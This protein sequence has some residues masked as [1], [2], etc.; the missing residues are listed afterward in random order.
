MG[1]NTVSRRVNLYING[2][3]AGREI[4]GVKAEM[5]KLVNEIARMKVG[6][7]EYVAH[8]QRIRELKAVVAEHN[9][10][11]QVTEKHWLSLSSMTDG[12]NK[13]F[14]MIGSFLAGLT[15]VVLGFRKCSDEAG[16][17]EENLDNLSALTGLEGK[18]LDWLGNQAK[19]MSVKTTESG[20]R[21][22]QSATDILD[23]F[24][25]M[26][27]QR[28]ELLKNKDAL[29]AV[30]EDAII[31]SEAAKMKLEPA[32]ASLASVM[33]Q[34]NT[35]SSESRR[36]IN[37]LAAGSQVGSGDIQY[38][39]DAI[40]KCGTSAYLMGMK[41]N[42][43][44]GVIEAV[45]PK[46]KEASVAGNSL[47]KVLLKMKEKQIGYQSGVFNF[48]DALDELQ[49]RLA[50][51]ESA[52]EL[53]G[54]EHAKMA[55]VLVLTKEDVIRYTEAVTDTNKA[56]EQAAKNTNNAVA[57]RAQA[58][59]KL[60]LKMIEVGEK[61]SPAITMSTNAFTYFLN[62]LVKA[63]R[64]YEENRR[65]IFAL[66][67][68][69]VALQGRT[70]LS[71]V[72][73][74]NGK[75]AHLQDAAAKMKNGL[76]T[77]YLNTYT[78][79][80]NRTQ[81]RLYPALLRAR[82]GFVML[83]RA[84]MANPIG[85]VVLAFTA[86][87]AAIDI[88]DSNNPT[89][90]RLEKEKRD[91]MSSLDTT[92]G[93]LSEKYKTYQAQISTLNRLSST[94]KKDLRDKISLTISA[95]EAE[96][97]N[98]K[99]KQ[100]Q[101]QAENSRP[102]VWDMFVNSLKSMG[103]VSKAVQYNIKDAFENG[104]KAADELNPGFEKLQETLAGLKNQQLNLDEI[105]NA[106]VN[107]DKIGTK[108]ITELQEK[109]NL[110]RVALESATVGGEEY[111]RILQKLVNTEKQLNQAIKNREVPEHEDPEVAKK[112]VEAEKKKAAEL[113]KEKEKVENELVNKVA[114][115]RKGLHVKS[116][117]ESERE[118][119]EVNQ[120]YAELLAICRKYGLS[121]NEVME[122]YSSELNVL[123]DKAVEAEVTAAIEAE[124]KITA[125][126]ASA[127][128]K[129]K[130]EIR[131]RY[132]DLLALAEKNGLD[133]A[134]LRAQL[135]EK[136]NKELDGVK[137]STGADLFGM[138]EE[139]WTDLAN[140]VSMALDLAGQL[141]DIWGQFNQIQ[142]NR[143]QKE[144]QD[145]EKSCNTK[146][147]LLNKQLNSGKI[148]QEK[149]NAQVAQLDADMDKKKTDMARK[150]AKRE[151]A[152]AI[153]N[154]IIN[155]ATAIM[156]IWSD[157]PK[158]DFGVSTAILTSLAAA[159]GA[160]QLGVILSAPLPEYATGGKTDG[161]KLYIAGEA[162][163]EWISPNWMLKDPV[164]GPIIERLELVRSGIMNPQDLASVVPDWQTMTSVPLYAGGGYAGN[165]M[166]NNYYTT[167][168]N[169]LPERDVVFDEMN[170]NIRAL[171]E[172]LTDERN[173]RAV[174]SN[175]LLQR[176]ND[177]MGVVNRLK[178]L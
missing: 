114:E 50:K 6:S 159:A 1:K 24:T 103:D 39:S 118:I 115:I 62:A 40:E 80:Y 178:R 164:T 85:A 110:Y 90:I 142:A 162:G 122:A 38:L 29:A 149:Y 63:P 42:Q 101:I 10:Q 36:I 96:I 95:T 46:F 171:C 130:A 170:K 75:I 92:L 20:V 156:R 3:E 65:L 160:A 125:T 26:G 147:E 161:A 58:M 7:D 176:N 138:T 88:Y 168:T 100:L 129:Q 123:F 111:N 148:S 74:L 173:R 66:I 124:D 8:A 109:V 167:T 144:L 97:A 53:F 25:K 102:K 18:D 121:A 43:A 34:F 152:T 127:T 141:T 14:G 35:K 68:A 151:R 32:T 17:F 166:Q 108:T 57:A 163:Q 11:L 54:V 94:E 21:I 77:V 107:A 136:M 51:G 12:F 86:L 73:T 128:E 169:L 19:E 146:K 140:K 99:A 82:T 131:Q 70:I 120:K 174:I 37:E 59:N 78:E 13:Y 157:V 52:A 9:R 84:M 83:G 112:R 30:T 165:N 49:T 55:E 87:K 106:E 67:A 69:F 22:R 98:Y 48:N 81:G 133:T 27:S 2:K 33:N 155:T 158:W 175:D 93:A 135:D 16:K 153:T 31:L 4:T 134:A 79:Q 61:I 150:Q 41:T 126:L 117:S 137:D 44:I 105:F 45:A 91:V 113:A 143:D 64:F 116:L 177:E 23:A 104:K 15:G 154:T 172:Y 145:Y 89:T 60:K 132:A 71:T 47:D 76:A 56:M 119:V 72:A 28:P 5:Q 139:D